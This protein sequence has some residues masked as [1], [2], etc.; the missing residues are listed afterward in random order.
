MRRLHIVDGTFELYRAHYSKRP[1]KTSPQGQ[2]VKATAGVMSSLVNLLADTTEQVT[3]LAVAF[4]HPIES[5][6]ND[7]YAGYKTGEGMESALVEQ[8]ALVEQGVRALGIVVWPMA[9]FEADDALATAAHRFA[10][11]VDQVRIMTPDKDLGQCV[12]AQ[13]VVQVDRMRQRVIDEQGVLQRHGVGP[14]CIPDWLALVGDTADGIPGIA[15]FGAKTAATLLNR[16][17]SLEAIPENSDDWQVRGA[18]RLAANLNAE[19]DAAALYKELATLRHDVPLAQTLDEL[20]WR[21]APQDEFLAFA[22]GLGG[23]ALRPRRYS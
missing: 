3:H 13:R 5:F 18:A 9:E 1:D 12:R 20:E 8:M 7:L 23:M 11:Q 16:Y 21:G 6:R 19:R 14:D 10:D 15:G 22:E 17:G 2:D 4:D